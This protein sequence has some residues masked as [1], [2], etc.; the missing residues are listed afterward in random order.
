MTWSQNTPTA[1]NSVYIRP[2]MPKG[3]SGRPTSSS[4]HTTSCNTSTR[5]E[6]RPEGQRPNPA[7]SRRRASVSPTS[8]PEIAIQRR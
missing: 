6:T 3:G 5:T 2:R 1:I 4:P 8:P 7:Y